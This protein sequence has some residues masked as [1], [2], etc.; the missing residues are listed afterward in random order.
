[1]TAASDLSHERKAMLISRGPSG[2]ILTADLPP[3]SVP[4]T[5]TKKQLRRQLYYFATLSV[6]LILYS[7]I[8][9]Q[10]FIAIGHWRNL[11]PPISGV[12]LV[13]GSSLHAYATDCSLIRPAPLT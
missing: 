7:L 6:F 1:M 5:P 8:A 10:A 2:S 9:V 12:C 13:Q 11:Y 4:S 3:I